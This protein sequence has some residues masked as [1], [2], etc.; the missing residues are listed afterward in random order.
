MIIA[1]K[2]RQ[3]QLHTEQVQSQQLYITLPQSKYIGQVASV[4]C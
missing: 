2:Q 3:M 4:R 1:G